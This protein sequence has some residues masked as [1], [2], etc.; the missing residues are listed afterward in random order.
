M[1]RN[2]G[3]RDPKTSIR[4]SHLVKVRWPCPFPELVTSGRTCT[5][6]T[7]KKVPALKSIATPVA[8]NVLT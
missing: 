7:Y 8:L 3:M 4:S 2:R 6:A 1:V 5:V